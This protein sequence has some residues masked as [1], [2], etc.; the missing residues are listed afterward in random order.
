VDGSLNHASLTGSTST[1]PTSMNQLANQS[2]IDDSKDYGSH[3]CGKR[4]SHTC[5]NFFILKDFYKN[6]EILIKDLAKR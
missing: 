6:Y 3:A 1:P 2:A 5:M 4:C